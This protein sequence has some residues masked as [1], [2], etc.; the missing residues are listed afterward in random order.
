M[1]SSTIENRY[2]ARPLRCGGP[3]SL[4]ARPHN[5]AAEQ[6][7]SSKRRRSKSRIDS[8]RIPLGKTKEPQTHFSYGTLVRTA[9]PQNCSEPP[10]L[11]ISTPGM[12]P[13]CHWANKTSGLLP[14]GD[15]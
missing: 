10:Y 3:L 5:R 11:L 13:T 2:M 8:T 14:C 7:P 1:N 4:D 9:R 12:A 15:L 6:P